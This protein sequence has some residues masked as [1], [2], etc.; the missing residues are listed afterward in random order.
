MTDPICDYCSK[1]CKTEGRWLV[2]QHPWTGDIDAR[3]CRN[4]AGRLS[5]ADEPVAIDA[6]A[7]GAAQRIYAGGMIR[8]LYRRICAARGITLTQD[9]VEIRLAAPAPSQDR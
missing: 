1:P 9:G 5:C 7:T 2:V 4:C 6:P 3:L 8:E